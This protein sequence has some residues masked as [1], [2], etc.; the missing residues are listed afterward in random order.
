M[1]AI[2]YIEVS[3]ESE[4]EAFIELC[5]AFKIVFSEVE[6]SEAKTGN[7]IFS[8]CWAREVGRRITDRTAGHNVMWYTEHPEEAIR[9]NCEIILHMPVDAPKIVEGMLEVAKT[10]FLDAEEFI[11][12][13]K[14][15]LSYFFTIG[16]PMSYKNT[17]I[18]ML[19]NGLRDLRE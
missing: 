15:Y 8:A 16:V 17:L 11:L 7:A 19:V 6:N 5:N 12:F 3:K 13:Y 10:A 14:A 2:E 18:E 9:E 1:R 4:K